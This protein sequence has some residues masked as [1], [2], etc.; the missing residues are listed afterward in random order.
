MRSER[1][2][3]RWPWGVAAV[4]SQEAWQGSRR[5]EPWMEVTGEAPD[6][7]EASLL[8][9]GSHWL[10]GAVGFP[11]FLLWLYFSVCCGS[12]PA[13]GDGAAQSLCVQVSE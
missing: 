6:L 13:V 3:A 12:Q 7:W 9:S 1:Y 5:G 8:A 11:G 10:N 2:L 4:F